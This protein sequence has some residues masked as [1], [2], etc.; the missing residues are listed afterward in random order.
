MELDNP[1]LI[2]IAVCEVGFW[3]LVLGGLGSRYVLRRRS[4]SVLM[5]TLLPVL[6]LILV[7]AV[8][9]DLHRGGEVGFAHRLAGIYLGW[10]VVFAHS[11]VAWLDVRFAHRFAGGPAPEKPP[12]KGPEAY[13]R[14]MRLFLKWLGAAGIA[15]AVTLGLSVTVASPAQSK[16]LL[17]VIPNLGLITVGWF[18]F[19]PLWVRGSRA[20][21]D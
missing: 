13:R 5:L 19:G 2:T 1:I 11:T 21:V 3:V 6:D 12:K 4:L 17:E 16:A 20:L 9:L 7:V 14:E 18:V 15:L 8:A 10:T